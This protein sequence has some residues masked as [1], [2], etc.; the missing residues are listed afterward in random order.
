MADLRIICHLLFILSSMLLHLVMVIITHTTP[1]LAQALEP[2]FTPGEAPNDNMQDFAGPLAPPTSLLG[3]AAPPSDSPT[4]DF[5][6]PSILSPAESPT[7]AAHSPTTLSPSSGS[8]DAPSPSGSIVTVS[9]SSPPSEV[10]PAPAFESTHSPPAPPLLAPPPYP[11]HSSL[12]SISSSSSSK[13]GLSAAQKAGISVGVLLSVA[14]AGL[15][16][17]IIKRRRHN[18][19]RSQHGH[20]QYRGYRGDT[21]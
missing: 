16:S 21:I 14:L 7:P 19:Q 12:P 13:E 3:P 8:A 18:I 17:F 6:A 4:I 9:T 10:A 2:T 15:V 20:S 11:W 5:R 1:A